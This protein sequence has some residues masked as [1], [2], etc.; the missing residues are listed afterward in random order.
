MLH[1]GALA[2]SLSSKIDPAVHREYDVIDHGCKASNM[3]LLLPL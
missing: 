2:S 1:N 3:G